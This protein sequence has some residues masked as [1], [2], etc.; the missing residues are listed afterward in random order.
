MWVNPSVVDSRGDTEGLG[1]GSIEAY[2]HRK[3]VVA[4]AVGGIPDTVEHGETGF[5]VPEKDSH[6]I[7]K[8]VLELVGDPA[9]SERF[10]DAGLEFA[11]RKFNWNTITDRT[12]REYKRLTTTVE[13]APRKQV[14]PTIG[15][16]VSIT[17]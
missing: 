3:P 10:G 6:A 8:S 2:A 1:V 11:Q 5:L 14:R 9:K 16:S 17:S 12:I 7:A 13:R 4:S 15:T